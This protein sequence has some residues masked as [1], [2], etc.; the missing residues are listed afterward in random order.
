VVVANTPPPGA[1]RVVY[2]DVNA[3]GVLPAAAKPVQV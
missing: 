2:V 1:G 3:H